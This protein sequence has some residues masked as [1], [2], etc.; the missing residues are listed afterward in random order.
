MLDQMRSA[1]KSW[2]AKLFLGLLGMSFL[3]SLSGYTVRADQLTL[4]D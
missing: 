2:V 1:A 3:N 4:V